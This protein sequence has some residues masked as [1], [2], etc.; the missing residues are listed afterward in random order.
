MSLVTGDA[1][2]RNI[3]V[4]GIVDSP[5]FSQMAFVNF[6]INPTVSTEGWGRHVL[7][8]Q[9]AVALDMTGNGLTNT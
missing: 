9:E 2:Q 3:Q 1:A 6:S 5:L 8:C 4:F 7:S